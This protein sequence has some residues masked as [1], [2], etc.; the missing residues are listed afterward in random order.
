MF[1]RPIWPPCAETTKLD[2]LIDAL[3]RVCKIFTE[4]QYLEIQ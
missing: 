3:S 1:L 2:H 4:I